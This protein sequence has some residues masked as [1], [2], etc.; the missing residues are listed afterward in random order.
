MVCVRDKNS[1]KCLNDFDL[2]LSLF[3]SSSA[4]NG[5]GKGGMQQNNLPDC[6]LVVYV[7]NLTYEIDEIQLG[8]KSGHMER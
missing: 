8:G 5:A 1:V 4:F 7:G 3:F 6:N 2:N